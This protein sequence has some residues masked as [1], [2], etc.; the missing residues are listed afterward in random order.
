MKFK[1]WP[2][3]L[4][5]E[6]RTNKEAMAALKN[7]EFIMDCDVFEQDYISFD[8][9]KEETTKR[10]VIRHYFTNSS[11]NSV[12]PVKKGHYIDGHVELIYNKTSSN[13]QFFLL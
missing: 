13:K 5:K 6:E 7:S 1:S 9:V 10:T 2:Y 8:G 12:N 3:Q 4:P 11:Y